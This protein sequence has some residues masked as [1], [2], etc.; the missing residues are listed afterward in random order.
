M[1]KNSATQIIHDSGLSV[2]R[3]VWK[4]SR[5]T[6]AG[7][8]KIVSDITQPDQTSPCVMEAELP[9]A[10]SRSD[11]WWNRP[12]ACRSGRPR[13]MPSGRS[14]SEKFKAIKAKKYKNSTCRFIRTQLSKNDLQNCPLSTFRFQSRPGIDFNPFDMHSSRSLLYL[15][16]LFFPFAGRAAAPDGADFKSDFYAVAFKTS[17]P[18]FTGFSVDSLGRGN[19]FLN[20]V[21]TAGPTNGP[22]HLDSASHGHF[23]YV[24]NSDDS[25][26]VPVWEIDLTKKEL[27]LCSRHVEGSPSPPFT[28]TMDQKKNHATLLGLMNEDGSI[29]LPAI[30]LLPDMGLFRISSSQAASLGYEAK[31]GEV[32]ITFPGAT[33]EHPALAYH[34]EVVSIYPAMAGIDA[35]ARFDGFRRNWLGVLQLNPQRRLLANNSSSDTAAFCYYEYADIAQR[36]PPLANGLSASDIVRQ[37]LDGIINGAKADGIPGYN[38]STSTP[39]FTADTL[40]SLLIAAHDCVDGSAGRR[41]LAKN[42]PHLKSWADTLLSTDRNG[43]GLVKYIVSGNSGSWPAHQEIQPGN[44]WDAIGFGHEDA[45]G[46]ALAYR[47][48]RGME[49]MARQSHHPDDQARY[50]AAAEKLH[51]A[52]FKTFYNPATGILAGWRSAD[53]KLHDYYFLWVN[54]I[55][56]HYGLVPKKEANLIMDRLL[57]KMKEVGYTRFDLGLPGNLVPVARKDYVALWQR[58]GGGSRED[59]LD[60]FQIYENGGATASFA[61]FTLAA[62]YDLGRIHDGDRILFPMLES[63]ARGDFQ[64]FG[65]NGMSKDW[66]AWD[67]TCWGYEGLL[68]DNYYALLAVLDRGAALTKKKTSGSPRSRRQP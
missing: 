39:E 62:F 61:Y 66:K 68:S 59:N 54:S 20:V 31:P 52:Y 64:G 27:T 15:L 7:T 36:T 23:S 26:N 41:W 1:R 8:T 34:C 22:F 58:V 18:E 6:M 60:G 65:P 13:P 63:F 53:G 56:I 43:D 42:Y 47:A 24:A 4:I 5:L 32:K 11:F 51:A 29:Q 57:A 50:R 45:Y 9:V 30:L 16:L 21:H 37:T 12:P 25:K 67:G 28:L 55:A 38:G 33:S 14:I 48:L 17:L 2:F 19:L 35:D 46:N 40:P 44:W 10:V 49:Q 3:A